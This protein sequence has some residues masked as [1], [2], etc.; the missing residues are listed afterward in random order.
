MRLQDKVCII[1]GAGS[2]MGRVASAL[3]AREGARVVVAEVN[4][5]AGEE[6]VAQVRAEGGDARLVRTDVTQEDE[7]RALVETTLRDYGRVDVLYNNAGIF[8]EQ[9]HSVV[10]TPVEVWERVQSVNVRGVYL[11]SKFAIP[12]MVDS[13]GGS[14][15]NVAS[16]VALVGCSVP[17]DS[18]TASKGA[19]IALTKSL[20]VQFGPRGVRSNAI[21]PGPIETPLMTAWLLTDPA[22]KALRLARIPMGRF[23]KAEDVA[24]LA[25]Y[26]AS[27]ESTW[28][29]GA[30]LVL[31][32]GITANY[33]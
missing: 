5:D 29:N 31:D 6:T 4:A 18:Y 1:T 20:A 7:C 9:D 3:F 27:D 15:V 14:V 30:A 10:D 17:Q 24:S 2:G 25:L 12:A 16:F 19:V 13:G 8:L 28:M 26:L 32:G 21:C 22:A 23:G 11:C 33:F